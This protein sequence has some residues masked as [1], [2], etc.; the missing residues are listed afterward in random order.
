VRLHRAKR[1]EL[2]EQPAYR[3]M[4]DQLGAASKLPPAEEAMLRELGLEA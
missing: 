1:D 4:A 2:L 3:A